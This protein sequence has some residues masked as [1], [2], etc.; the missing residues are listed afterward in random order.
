MSSWAKAP[1]LADRP[2]Q[3]AAV[4]E[5][6]VADRDAYLRDGLRPV[7]CERCAARVLAK[8][9][10]PQHTSVQWSAESARQC[11]VFAACTPGEVV[12]SCPDLQRSIAAAAGDG[13]LPPP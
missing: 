12:E 4:R 8:K 5:G 11:A 13:R 7:E 3:R 1:D 9:N 10:S 6:T 2:H